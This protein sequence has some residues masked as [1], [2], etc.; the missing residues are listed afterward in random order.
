VND[1][2]YFEHLAAELRVAAWGSSSGAAAIL[3]AGLAGEYEGLARLLRLSHALARTS[4]RQF[5]QLC[6]D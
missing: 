3:N 5:E 1:A 4:A 2:L 6:Q